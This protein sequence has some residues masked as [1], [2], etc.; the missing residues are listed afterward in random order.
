MIS[1]PASDQQAAR[2]AAGRVAQP[3]HDGRAEEAAE[4]AGRVDQARCRPPPPC[5]RGTS[6]AAP[7]TRRDHRA[8][9][10]LRSVKLSTSSQVALRGHR[11][12]QPDRGVAAHAA[13]WS[14]RSPV[15]S[16]CRPTSTIATSAATNGIDVIE[17][18]A[19]PRAPDTSCSIFGSHRKMPYVTSVFMNSTPQ[20]SHTRPL[21]KLAHDRV[22]DRLRDAPARPPSSAASQ[23]A[24]VRRQPRRL[25]RADR[26]ARGSAS[27]PSTT[28]GSPSIRNSHCQPCRPSLPSSLEQRLRHRPADD[29]RDR[30]GHHEQGAGPGALGGRN[31]VR[32][33]QTP[34]PG[35]TL[36]RR[37]RAARGRP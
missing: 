21:A 4:V 17:L 18:S 15:R 6:A 25:S 32:Q 35:R 2:V 13:T 16:E 28:A 34:C 3:A 7:R 29:H 23:L 11:Q 36:P 24:V 1:A 20:S 27:T 33:V 19:K 30:R 5:R 26:S 12:Q 9:G 37:S 14:L 8:L 31:P 10:H 22:P